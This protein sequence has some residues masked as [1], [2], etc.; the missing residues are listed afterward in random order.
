MPQVIAYYKFTPIPGPEEFCEEHK[1][2]CCL[3]NLKGRIYIAAEGINGTVAGSSEDIAAYTKRLLAIEGFRGTQFKAHPCDEIPFDRLIVKTRPEIVSLK[4]SDKLNVPEKTAAFLSPSEW[5]R[6]L[7]SEKDFVLIDVRNDYESAIGHFENAVLPPLE[8]FYDFPEWLEQNPV[9]KDKKVLMYCTGGIRCEKFSV[10]MKQKGYKNVF[11]LEGGILNYTE[12][13]GGAHFKGKCFVFDDRM[14]VPVDP[15]ETEP[16]GRCEISG[17]PC[18]TYINCANMEC[19]K[20]F[21]CD[22]KAAIAMDGCCSE[23]CRQA[24]TR[25][26]LNIEKLYTPFR[27]KH[28]CF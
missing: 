28:R 16:I 27:R 24:P 21:L 6:T 11:Q 1:E 14:A 15:S 17:V 7:E 9:E 8:N 20:L 22:R 13:E 25:R 12:A 23:K 3:L 18:D 10:L 19:N 4:V 26:P 2:L 5:R